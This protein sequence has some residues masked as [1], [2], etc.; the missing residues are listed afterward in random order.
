MGG[1]VWVESHSGVGSTFNFTVV[2]GQDPNDSNLS[3]LDNTLVGRRAL[4]VDDNA[5]SRE[6][7]KSLLSVWGMKVETVDTGWA[8]LER[9]EKA[10]G[11][12]VV[13]V[14]QHMPVMDGEAL[15][16]RIHSMRYR[17]RAETCDDGD[18]H[19]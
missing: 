13:M 6:M 1:D 5:A 11:V 9:L 16:R 15:V 8:A 14:D 10:G 2:V 18:A 12:D 19:R 3:K 4:V 17:P 7:F